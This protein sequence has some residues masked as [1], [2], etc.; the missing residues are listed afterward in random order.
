MSNSSPFAIG[1]RWIIQFW[2]LARRR[3]KWHT[4]PRLADEEVMQLVQQGDPRACERLY[5]PTAELRS[6]GLR[7]VGSR[8]RRGVVQ[9]ASPVDLAKRLRYDKTRG[10]AH[11]GARDRAQ[12]ASRVV[13]AACTREQARDVDVVEDV[14][15]RG[16]GRSGVARKWESVAWG[17]LITLPDESAGRSSSLSGGYTKS[18]IA[19]CREPFGT[20]RDGCG[21]ASTN[22]ARAR[23]GVQDRYVRHQTTWAHTSSMR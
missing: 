17:T 2:W 13:G 22:E 23:G 5:D 19:T 7:M 6:P 4:N 15:R 18:E 16:S 10:A 8:R 3:W 12:P 9:G 1:A 14:T 20:V 11:M 21:L